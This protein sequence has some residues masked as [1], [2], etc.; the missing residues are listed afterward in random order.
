MLLNVRALAKLVRCKISR[1][2]YLANLSEV[3]F[4][5]FPPLLILIVRTNVQKVDFIFCSEFK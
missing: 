4:A 3:S 5:L 1:S 2:E